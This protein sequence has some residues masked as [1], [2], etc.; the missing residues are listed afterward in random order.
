MAS[1]RVV[2]KSA[3]VKPVRRAVETPEEQQHD[4]Q[5]VWS[6]NTDAQKLGI[7]NSQPAKT[8]SKVVSFQI[9]VGNFDRKRS[10]EK[11]IEDVRKLLK[12]T[13]FGTDGIHASAL[14]QY[15][16]VDGK[17]CLPDDYD[18]KK[19]NFGDQ[20]LPPPWAGGPMPART[21]PTRVAPDSGTS[22]A[23]ISAKSYD[24]KYGPGGS[25]VARAKL[26]AQ[27]EAVKKRKEGPTDD[28]LEDIDFGFLDDDDAVE[29]IAAESQKKAA[30]KISVK[31]SG[32]A[33]KVVRRKTTESA[34]KPT[35]VVRRKK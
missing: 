7:D 28:E 1:R 17:V 16:V 10:I 6:A 20:K 32:V 12:A 33:K 14:S 2:K 13:P 18:P 30:R 21:K 34:S 11:F 27:H 26:D 15:Y 23:A 4:T 8:V 25:P 5:I 3:A 31:R 35:R 9:S 22:T 24:A 29:K 19:E